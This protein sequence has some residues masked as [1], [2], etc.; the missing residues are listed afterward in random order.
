MLEDPKIPSYTFSKNHVIIQAVYSSSDKKWNKKKAL[1]KRRWKA[2]RNL[3]SQVSSKALLQ[4]GGE[5]TAEIPFYSPTFNLFLLLVCLVTFFIPLMCAEI[6]QCA[7]VVGTQVEVGT[8]RTV[9][10]IH[11]AAWMLPLI[12]MQQNPAL[13]NNGAIPHFHRALRWRRRRENRRKD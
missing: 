13:H 1:M 12:S 11:R 10:V 6:I 8:F 3:C 4:C 7:A 9:A 5:E 2:V